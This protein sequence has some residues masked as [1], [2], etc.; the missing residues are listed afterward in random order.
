MPKSPKPVEF[1]QIAITSIHRLFALDQYGRL[2]AADIKESDEGPD[3]DWFAI[4]A[5]ED[6]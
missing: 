1:K 3:A 5:P 4:D 6:D 2:W